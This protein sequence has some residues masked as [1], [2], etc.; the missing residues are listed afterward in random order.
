MP[1][2]PDDLFPIT[3]EVVDSILN[4]YAM[5]RKCMS[6]DIQI[7]GRKNQSQFHDDDVI[8]IPVTLA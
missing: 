3:L 5:L 7:L 8:R 6:L 2:F 1:L 4:E